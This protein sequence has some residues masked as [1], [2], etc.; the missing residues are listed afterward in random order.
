MRNFRE[1]CEICKIFIKFQEFDIIFEIIKKV[2]S[3]IE[4]KKLVEHTLEQ[5]KYLNDIL[6]VEAFCWIQ[7]N[8]HRNAIR[9]CEKYLQWYAEHDCKNEDVNDV[10]NLLIEAFQ[11]VGAK[12]LK[13]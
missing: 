8:E 11:I 2:K 10:K 9:I 4:E 3:L 12:Y 6:I 13:D 5:Q 7:K 1:I